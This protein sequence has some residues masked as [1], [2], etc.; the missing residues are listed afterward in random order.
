MRGGFNLEYGDLENGN[1]EL[2]LKPRFWATIASPITCPPTNPLPLNPSPHTHPRGFS[3]LPFR[4]SRFWDL[5]SPY[6]RLMTFLFYICTGTT[7]HVWIVSE[8]RLDPALAGDAQAAVA[9]GVERGHRPQ[10]RDRLDA[11]H[12]ARKHDIHK[13]GKTKRFE[14][15]S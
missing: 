7:E 9:A 6:S 4:E 2:N 5:R 8:V 11:V 15:A 14:N 1:L 12:V 13:F 10:V 3:R